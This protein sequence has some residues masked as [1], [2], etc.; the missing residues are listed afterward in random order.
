MVKKSGL[1]ISAVFSIFCIGCSQNSL[2]GLLQ[3]PVDTKLSYTMDTKAIQGEGNVPTEQEKPNAPQENL[4]DNK[5]KRPCPPP[6]PPCSDKAPKQGEAPEKEQNLNENALS[7]TLLK[8]ASSNE[9]VKPAKRPCPPPPPPCSDKAPK[10][11]EAP[12]KE[13]VENGE[14]P[15][16]GNNDMPPPPKKECKKDENQPKKDKMPPPPKEGSQ[17]G[18]IK[19]GEQSGEKMKPLPQDSRPTQEKGNSKDKKNPPPPKQGSGDKQ[20]G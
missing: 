9:E 8:D 20:R 3:S 18:E 2:D 13:Q 6:P 16:N 7:D 15:E 14:K 19:T 17:Q 12:E 5:S 11:G 4:K 1:L 10:Q